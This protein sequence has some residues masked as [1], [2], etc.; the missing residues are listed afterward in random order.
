MLNSLLNL[1][2]PSRSAAG[3]RE[4]LPH[5]RTLGLE[6]ERLLKVVW[7]DAVD[8]GCL[9]IGGSGDFG[10]GSRDTYRDPDASQILTATLSKFK[11]HNK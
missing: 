11:I 9:W 10:M 3:W 6:S 4:L 5:G 2:D 1:Q 7:P 8:E